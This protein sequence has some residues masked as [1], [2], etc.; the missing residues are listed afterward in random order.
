[1]ITNYLLEK[2]RITSPGPNER[3]FHIFYHLLAGASMDELQ[4]LYLSDGQKKRN[5]EQFRFLEIS[6]CFVVDQID[7][8]RLYH[9]V[10]QAFEALNFQDYQGTVFSL[11][12]AILHMGNIDFDDTN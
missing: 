12:S 8:V 6:K 10:V 1:M 11:V 3:N 7:D 9:E 5:I 2:S 4:R